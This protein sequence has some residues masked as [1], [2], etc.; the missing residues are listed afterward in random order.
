MAP[1]YWRTNNVS[2]PPHPPP[3]PKQKNNTVLHTNSGRLNEFT[4]P[5]LS[6][7]QRHL[8]HDGGLLRHLEDS[9]SGER[10]Q[11][12]GWPPCLQP[13]S[14]KELASLKSHSKALEALELGCPTA[15]VGSAETGA[16]PN[17]ANTNAQ[18]QTCWRQRMALSR[19]VRS[20]TDLPTCEPSLRLGSPRCRPRRLRFA[21]LF[22][23]RA[24]PQPPA[25]STHGALALPGAWPC[26]SWPPAPLRSRGLTETPRLRALGSAGAWASATSWLLPAVRRLSKA[27]KMARK[28]FLSALSSQTLGCL[29]GS[30]HVRSALEDRDVGL[31]QWG[32][33]QWVKPSQPSPGEAPAATWQLRRRGGLPAL[34]V[35]AG[36]GAGGC[37]L[38]PKRSQ[39]ASRG[40]HTTCFSS[41][42]KKRSRGT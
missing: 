32:S 21:L 26:S 14:Q 11:E 7:R 38:V 16:L 41:R 33:G 10:M 34:A 8:V 27:W 39:V 23:R 36:P 40:V 9:R 18:K 22:L 4:G 12:G 1:C 30:C 2:L 15:A 13:N 3:H 17:P 37:R 28:F 6:G 29:F 35:P 5:L 19:H 25:A 24:P 42:P 20:V 31:P